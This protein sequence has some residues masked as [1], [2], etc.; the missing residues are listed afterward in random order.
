MSEEGKERKSARF[1]VR[2]T[3]AELQRLQA[4]RQAGAR[5]LSDVVRNL[6]RDHLR[7]N[8]RPR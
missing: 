1:T 6:I 5:T 4:G 3:D 8:P 2:L 7:S